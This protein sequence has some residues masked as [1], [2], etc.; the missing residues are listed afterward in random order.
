MRPPAIGYL[1]RDISGARRSWDEIQIRTVARR[2]GYE[3][4]KTVVFSE[5]TADP[6]KQVTT[7][8]RAA[9]AEAVVV[10]SA[11]HLGG[12]IPAALLDA[13]QVITV[14][15]EEAHERRVPTIFDPRPDQPIDEGGPAHATG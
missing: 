3:L 7:A 10:P 1:R 14:T 6:I 12:E 11:E 8:A 13:A 15:P 4:A 5:M 9:G 2:L